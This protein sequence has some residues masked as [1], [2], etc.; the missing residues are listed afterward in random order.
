MD[1]DSTPL[2]FFRKRLRIRRDIEKGAA[3]ARSP[4]FVFYQMVSSPIQRAFKALVLVSQAQDA[5]DLKQ[6][7][8]AKLDSRSPHTGN[9]LFDYCNWFGL[10]GCV[11]S[12]F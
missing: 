7:A 8:S 9:F 6:K 2:S 5:V 11:L 12:Y 1:L 4:L 3:H 10:I